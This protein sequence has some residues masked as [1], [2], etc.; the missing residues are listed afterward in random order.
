MDR[1]KIAA[2]LVTLAKRIMEAEW[3][4]LRKDVGTGQRTTTKLDSQSSFAPKMAK[5]MRVFL[6]NELQDNGIE[7]SPNALKLEWREYLT[8]LDSR[9]NNNKYH[10]YVVYSFKDS[11]GETRY[12]AGNCNGRIGFIER[13]TDLTWKNVGEYPLSE[14]IAV[15]AVKKHMRPKLR[16]GYE[17]TKMT[18]G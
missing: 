8:Y 9:R 11:L 3:Q 5:K 12:I 14:S 4:P 15:G 6:A 16:K 18:R 2:K 7:V 1:K 13:Q 10:Y 17:P